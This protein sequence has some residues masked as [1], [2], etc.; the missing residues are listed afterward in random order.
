MVSYVDKPTLKQDLY[1][2]IME[3]EGQLR[4]TPVS[5]EST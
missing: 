1:E 4:D 5:A 2:M 3:A